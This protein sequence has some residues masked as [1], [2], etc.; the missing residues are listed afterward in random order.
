M[1][2]GWLA[3]LEWALVWF[4]IERAV[5]DG[6][7]L[8][9]PPFLV[10]SQSMFASGQYPKFREQAYECRDD[11]LVLIPT[12][13]VAL[14]NL[15]RDE[16]LSEEELPIRLASFTPSFRRE[17]GAYGKDERGLIRIHQFNKVE[18][19]ALTKPE[20]SQNEL[21]LMVRHAEK[22]M[23]ELELPYRTTLLAA[24]DLAHQSAC[25]YDIEVWLPGQES[26]S[27]VS[28]VSNCTDYQARRAG[29]RYRPQGSKKTEF[30]HTLNGS[31]LA[32]SRLMVAILEQYQ[33]PD[34]GL[35]VPP[36]LR[37]YIGGLTRIEPRR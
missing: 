14:L 24:G 30:V 25:T 9:L 23:E 33:E 4:L 3:R 22:L 32:T 21:K 36:V 10:N 12:S 7:E 2:R 1:Y 26:F 16:I 8:I 31:A 35:T 19:F 5:S 13:E 20:E 18:I 34:G 29:I 15:Y 27:E 37:P 28:S 17:A 6:R 11:D